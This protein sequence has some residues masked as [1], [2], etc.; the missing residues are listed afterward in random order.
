MY[1]DY[2]KRVHNYNK[3][4]VPKLLLKQ[5]ILISV[6]LYETGLFVTMVLI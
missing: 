4:V 6:E 1:V 3:I 2:K 5:Q